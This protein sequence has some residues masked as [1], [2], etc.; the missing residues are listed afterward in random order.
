M[1]YCRHSPDSDVWVYRGPHSYVI[2]VAW[3]RL[4][5]GYTE[6]DITKS[7]METPSNKLPLPAETFH[8]YDYHRL[9]GRN[10]HPMNLT[11]LWLKLDS[12][13]RAGLR[14]PDRAMDQIGKEMFE[15]DT[16]VPSV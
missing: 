4:K 14:V 3:A 9:A 5:P 11:A 7:I 10:Y 6:Q 8:A 12:L 2:S 13:K 16:A 1:S 15:A